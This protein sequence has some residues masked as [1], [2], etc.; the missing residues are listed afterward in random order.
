[1]R[2]SRE[3]REFG[4]EPDDR[5]P[6][7]VGV[8]LGFREQCVR[9]PGHRVGSFAEGT[10]YDHELGRIAERRRGLQRHVAD[11]E[12]ADAVS[13]RVAVAVYRCYELVARSKDLVCPAHVEIADVLRKAVELP[14]QLLAA[15]GSMIEFLGTVIQHLIRRIETSEPNRLD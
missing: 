10:D 7:R 2:G 14:L 15:F 1:M 11:V 3:D 13:K 12:Q 4:G 9:S 8:S 5:L 6:R